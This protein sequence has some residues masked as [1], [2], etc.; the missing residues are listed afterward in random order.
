MSQLLTD[1]L[2]DHEPELQQV[3][4]TEM[5]KW[6]VRFSTV[7]A[8]IDPLMSHVRPLKT[9]VIFTSSSTLCPRYT[10]S[11]VHLPCKFTCRFFYF[12]RMC[13]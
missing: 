7:C 2:R 3:I 10:P 4:N 12:S 11:G 5:R 9:R 6:E 13:P 1:D 8:A